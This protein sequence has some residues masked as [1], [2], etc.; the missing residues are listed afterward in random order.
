LI[1]GLKTK[2]LLLDRKAMRISD[3]AALLDDDMRDVIAAAAVSGPASRIRQ[4]NLN[5]LGELAR[6]EASSDKPDW[7]IYRCIICNSL[8]R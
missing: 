3:A 8:I 1:K 6:A 2:D 7:P 5:D 4:E